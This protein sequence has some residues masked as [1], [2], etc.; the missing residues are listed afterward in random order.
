M[1]VLQIADILGWVGNIFFIIGSVLL[2]KKK[3]VP[4][5]I[6]N[7]VGNGIYIIVGF[8]Q[9]LTSLW[10]ISIFLLLLA[11]YGIYNWSKTDEKNKVIPK[12]R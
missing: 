4:C 12:T 8:M 11:I 2:A 1:T 5:C 6:T 9:N 7:V 3:P 10:A